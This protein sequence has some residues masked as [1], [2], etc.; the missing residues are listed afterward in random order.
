MQ[1]I[2]RKEALFSGLTTYFTGAPCKYGHIA[3]RRTACKACTECQRARAAT[4]VYRDRKRR[5][6]ATLNARANRRRWAGLPIPTRPEP[7][8]C[9]I[10]CGADNKAL[11]LDHDHRTGKFRGWLCGRCNSGIGML[12]DSLTSIARVAKYLTGPG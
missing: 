6:R 2:T 7:E 9:E 12:G 3:K 10:C 5:Q 11:A 4:S 8:L 1:I